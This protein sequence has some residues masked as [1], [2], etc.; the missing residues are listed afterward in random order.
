MIFKLKTPTITYLQFTEDMRC[1]TDGRAVAAARGADF[2]GGGASAPS[3][4]AASFSVSSD[5]VGLALLVWCRLRL[6]PS[7]FVFP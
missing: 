4:G 1:K 7:A 3:P 6:L 2:P 5:L